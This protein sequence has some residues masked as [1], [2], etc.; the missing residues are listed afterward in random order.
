MRDIIQKISV[1]LIKFQTVPYVGAI[2]FL[3]YMIFK[4]ISCFILGVCLI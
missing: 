1:S 3:V 2:G 4:A